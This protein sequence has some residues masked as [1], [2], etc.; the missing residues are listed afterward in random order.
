GGPFLPSSA[1][2]RSSLRPPAGPLMLADGP[3]PGGAGET[4]RN[5]LR[6]A[7]RGASVPRGTTRRRR[8]R[9]SRNRDGGTG[10]TS[11]TLV[12]GFGSADADELYGIRSWS[13]GY[14]AVSEQGELT[15][16]VRGAPA[17]SI[18][19]IVEDLRAQGHALPLVL[20]FP[21]VLEDRL[22]RVNE[23]FAA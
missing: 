16:S 6:Y 15:V 11:A 22:D 7:A 10:E 17:A 23:A 19:G 1:A 4:G 5:V 9:T 8:P 3:A 21:D 20:R 2:S 14:F 13:N 12:P 18:A